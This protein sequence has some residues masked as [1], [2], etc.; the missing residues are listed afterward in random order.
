MVTYRVRAYSWRCRTCGQGHQSSFRL[1]PDS[2]QV[3]KGLA[4]HA[5]A[6]GDE[7]KRLHAG[8]TVT[9]M[10]VED[11]DETDADLPDPFPRSG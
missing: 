3:T 4:Q 6:L 2:P 11:R 10:D 7:W 9:P 5:L 8:H 1:D